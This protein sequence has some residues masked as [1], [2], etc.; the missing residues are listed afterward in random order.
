MPATRKQRR[1]QALCLLTLA[2]FSALWLASC[3]SGTGTSDEEVA[4]QP[5]ITPEEPHTEERSILRQWVMTAA[6]GGVEEKEWPSIPL[7]YVNSERWG[8]NL[9]RE[10]ESR[11]VGSGDLAG[12]WDCDASLMNEGRPGFERIGCMIPHPGPELRRALY[13]EPIWRDDLDPHR[14]LMGAQATAPEAP[15]YDPQ[16]GEDEGPPHGVTLSPFWIQRMEVTI[17]QYRW[18]LIFGP[19]QIEDVGVGGAFNFDGDLDPNHLQPPKRS[20]ERPIGGVTWRGA[21][22][23]CRWI[24]GRLPTEAEWEYAAR[25]GPLGLTYPWGDAPPTCRHATFKGSETRP[26]DVT[27]P[28]STFPPEGHNTPSFMIHQAGNL[29]EWTADW[30][31]E[32]Y[33]ASSPSHDPKGPPKGKGRVQRGGS[34]SDDDASVLRGAFRAQMDPTL[35]MPDVG[36]RCAANQVQH[37]PY[38]RLY[39]PDAPDSAWHDHAPE[40]PVRWTRV[41]G[42]IRAEAGEKTSGLKWRPGSTSSEVMLSM[43]IYPEVGPRGS[44]A[45]LYGVQDAENHYRAEVY[46]GAGVVRIIR[47]LDGVEGLIAERS[48][49]EFPER[50]WLSLNI[51]WDKGLHR[52]AHSAITLAQGEDST[53]TSGGV[54]MRILGPGKATFEPAFTTP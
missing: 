41:Q 12:L 45:L 20:D 24:G 22:R 11:T 38:T 49:V 2:C 19:C 21:Q 13:R 32:D 29:W 46:P 18:C 30:Y 15:G 26:C 6:L 28:V 51:R 42:F 3:R 17:R 36:F 14:F 47:V 25:S 9:L 44:V 7:S 52:L 50:W 8:G 48:G 31:A 39:Q 1:T 53:W 54:G 27:G 33:Y 5:P 43:R 10:L 34:F 16:A 4:V 23:Y 40:G 35:K 37:I